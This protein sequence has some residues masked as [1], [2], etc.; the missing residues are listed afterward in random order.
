MK[1]FEYHKR[2]KPVRIAVRA[3]GFVALCGAV[4]LS[5]VMLRAFV[6][7]QIFL[8]PAREEGAG[9]YLLFEPQFR[10][11]RLSNGGIG[12]WLAATGEPDPAEVSKVLV[13]MPAW[14]PAGLSIGILIYAAL[15]VF[16]FANREPENSGGLGE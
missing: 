9:L 12:V 14:L 13:S 6:R 7:E 11:F 15:A 4:L 10:V 2:I 1:P 16:D 5:V 3:F 8:W